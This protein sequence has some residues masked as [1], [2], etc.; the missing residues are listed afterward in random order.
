MS[1]RLRS[2]SEGPVR[3]E[4]VWTERAKVF[5]VFLLMGL[6]V[7]LG[8]QG[9]EDDWIDK[10]GA[11]SKAHQY[12]ASAVIVLSF[13]PLSLTFVPLDGPIYLVAGFMFGFLPG[14]LLCWFG[15]NLGSWV[16]FVV[17]RYMFRSW[18]LSRTRGNTFVQAVR[19]AVRDNALVLVML[20]QVAPI[21]P[22]SM[23]CYFFGTSDCPF[24]T[25]AGGTALGVIP[26]TLFFT[27]IGS[28]METIAEAAQGAPRPRSPFHPSRGG[29]GAAGA[30][31]ATSSRSGDAA[32]CFYWVSGFAGLLL[33]R[34]GVVLLLGDG[35]AGLLTVAFLTVLAKRELDAILA[36][37]LAQA[38]LA[39]REEAEAADAGA[40]PSPLTGPLAG[41]AVPSPPPPRG[42]S[43]GRGGGGIESTEDMCAGGVSR[44]VV[45]AYGAAESMLPPQPYLELDEE[46]EDTGLQ[47]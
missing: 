21:M 26:N 46:S 32:W 43:S 14:S 38:G 33:G 3:T 36:H 31:A 7:A 15:Y 8:I 18:F 4:S 30:G 37:T 13:I 29:G 23:V 19:L 20:L 42:I 47:F 17:G 2:L 9:I 45:E 6:A 44:G 22:Y 27:F 24:S 39:A 16:G 41:P 35:F 34:R 28:S 10:F 12:T 5:G 1:S 11:F 25:Y 40:P